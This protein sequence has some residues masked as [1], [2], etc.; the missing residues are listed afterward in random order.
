[1]PP[2]GVR[3]ATL[4]AAVLWDMDGTLAD[5]E[6]AWIAAEHRLVA[7]HGGRW[8]DEHSL[9]L[10]GSDLMTAAS[11]I[12][13]HGGVPL[14]PEQIV[15]TLLDDVVGQVAR[16]IPWQPGAVELLCSLRDA[17]VPCAL[18]TMSWTRLVGAVVD[19]LPG[20]AFGCV[21]AGDAVGRGKPHPEPYLRA[22]A[23]LD[24]DPRACV[25][26]ED[27]PTGAASAEAAGCHVLAVPHAV[28]VPPGPGRT[29]VPSLAG[30]DPGALGALVPRPV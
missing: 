3:V 5:T 13:L 19:A 25:A 15:H 12:R 16:G 7:A 10:V 1:M 22:A 6:P 8:S 24:V 29:V 30:L 9:A 14:E 17:G 28:D 23:A 20:G 2:E 11:Y 18:V 4:P 21:V 26:I 27:S